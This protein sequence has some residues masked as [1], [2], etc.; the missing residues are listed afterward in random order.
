MKTFSLNQVSLFSL[1]IIRIGTYY[2]FNVICVW[3]DCNSLIKLKKCKSMKIIRCWVYVFF[4]F[5]IFFQF[6]SF[7]Y[8]CLIVNL[9]VSFYNSKIIVQFNYNNLTW[10]I[11][12]F[13]KQHCIV[14]LQFLIDT[15]CFS[16]F[17]G[18]Y[19]YFNVKSQNDKL[20]KIKNILNPIVF[21]PECRDVRKRKTKTNSV[22]LFYAP[23]H[24]SWK[25][26]SEK[27]YYT[28]AG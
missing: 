12:F 9:Y 21:H 16:W 27:H 22:I 10:R 5:W 8:Y 11:F 24:P 13:F 6:H 25:R 17:Q 26:F 15:R 28:F 19:N 1:K 3:N 14:C 2:G 4:R 7:N 18:N 23:G 20:T